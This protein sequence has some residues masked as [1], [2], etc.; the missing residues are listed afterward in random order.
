MRLVPIPWPRRCPKNGWYSVDHPSS[1]I[2]IHHHHHHHHHRLSPS[3]NIHQYPSLSINIHPLSVIIHQYPSVFHHYP[4]IFGFRTD[5]FRDPWARLQH[6][7]TLDSGRSRSPDQAWKST[8]PAVMAFTWGWVKILA[9]LFQS[10]CYYRFNINHLLMVG[11][12]W[13]NIK[14][15]I[16][17]G[18]PN[19]DPYPHQSHWHVGIPT[20]GKE[21]EQATWGERMPRW[22]AGTVDKRRQ[23]SA[24]NIMCLQIW[25]FSKSWN[26]WN[27]WRYN[28]GWRWWKI[29]NQRK[30]RRETPCYG[31][32][33][34]Q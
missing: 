4:S 32:S 11:S 27:I 20:C 24:E 22:S 7:K 23:I 28:D 33:H 16:S 26:I 15:R 13:L 25:V 1:S 31:L 30:F 3:I 14:H 10:I 8:R 2:I 19:I 6:G 5:N 17:I 21:L 9:P 12:I 18:V 29:V 34:S